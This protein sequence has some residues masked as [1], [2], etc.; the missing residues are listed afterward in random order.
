MLD[1]YADQAEDAISGNHN[2]FSHYRDSEV[3]VRRLSVYIQRS[4]AGALTL[5][6]GPRHAV[7]VASMVAMYLAKESDG[8]QETKRARREL[9]QAGGSLVR[10]LVPLLRMWRIAY[11]QQST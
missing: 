6:Q 8:T 1:N 10:L 7:I 4:T 11:G 2:Y 5:P 3:G 9:A